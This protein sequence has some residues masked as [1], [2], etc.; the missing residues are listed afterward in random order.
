MTTLVFAH[1]L[2]VLFGMGLLGLGLFVLAHPSLTRGGSL[3]LLGLAV[4]ER[5]SAPVRRWLMSVTDTV[6]AI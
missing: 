1:R 2:Y 3:V 5:R 4:L 6:D